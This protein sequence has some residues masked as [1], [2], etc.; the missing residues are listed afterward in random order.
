[1]LLAFTILHWKFCLQTETFIWVTHEP[2]ISL[3]SLENLWMVCH[4]R[5]FYNKNLKMQFDKFTTTT[6]A[7]TTGT[8]SQ[9]L[10]VLVCIVCVSSRFFL[11]FGRLKKEIIFERF[12]FGP[13]LHY[14]AKKCWKF[15]LTE[16]LKGGVKKQPQQQQKKKESQFKL[17]PFQTFAVKSKKRYN[18]F[19][20]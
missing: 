1:M 14:I 3:A 16:N 10:R 15:F 7:A 19:I 9:L 18:L 8:S 13:Q 5:P 4:R 6:T 17:P 2:W 12:F 20:F 11:R